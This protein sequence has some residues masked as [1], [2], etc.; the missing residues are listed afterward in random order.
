M[1]GTPRPNQLF[2]TGKDYVIPEGSTF[3]VADAPTSDNH[4]VRKTDLDGAVAALRLGT[5][6]IARV[7]SSVAVD[8][9]D[10]PANVD[11]VALDADDVFLAYGQADP[12]DNGLY[13]YSAEAGAASRLVNYDDNDEI[14]A[15][16]LVAVQDGTHEE[17]VFILEGSGSLTIGTDDL[18]FSLLA[19]AS[20]IADGSVTTAK[21][22]ADAV[23]GTKIA[24]DAVDSEHIAAD[25]VDSE[26][27][28]AGAIDTEH[29][30]D[31]QVTTAKIAADA[32]DGTLIADDAVDS[33]HIADGAIDSAHIGDA[34]VIEAKIA[35]GAVST[36]KI[37]DDA[38]T[39]A[40][41]AT[42]VNGL[43]AKVVNVPAQGCV[44][45]GSDDDAG[46]VTYGG[47][48]DTVDVEAGTY[49]N[50]LGEVF[51][52]N[53]DT[54]I[55]IADADAGERAWV[56][57]VAKTNGTYDT[58]V[59]AGESGAGLPTEPSLG[60]GDVL[61]ARILK[62]AADY[63]AGSG[64]YEAVLSDAMIHDA[65]RA[66]RGSFRAETPSTAGAPT[67][68]RLARRMERIGGAITVFDNGLA[69]KKVASGAGAGEF[70]VSADPQGPGD[71]V[72][73]GAA[74]GD[75][76]VILINYIG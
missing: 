36:D 23:D 33:E 12:V 11:G 64:G 48:S 76:D 24:D 5:T 75:D 20:A 39:Q 4:L 66:L 18:V 34:Q 1:A 40:K 67:T 74:A 32:I 50:S 63:F 56:L 44:D 70:S 8:L 51:S 6:I 21:L 27:L 29:L 14:A 45:I 46:L 22:A 52:C 65:R 47:A 41:L 10:L 55:A 25:A 73:I 61:L 3:S 15:S 19:L 53:A 31:G 28:A 38:I 2:S 35:T 43:F 16:A 59:G 17:K 26:H 57:V 68:F 58:I 49:V 30:G 42:V 54:G 72:T 7:A 37:A 60:A 71:L 69:L 9:A 13:V 62:K